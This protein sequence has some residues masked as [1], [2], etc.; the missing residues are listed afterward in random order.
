MIM[1]DTTP[2][3][4]NRRQKTQYV[5]ISAIIVIALAVLAGIIVLTERPQATPPQGAAYQE[6]NKDMGVGSIVSKQDVIDTLGTNG[7]DVKDASISAVLNYKGNRGQTATYN[8]T[9]P[10]GAQ[11]GS[12]DIDIM[13]Y[14]N[15]EAFD[16]AMPLTG[17][18]GLGE[19]AGHQIKYLP[20]ITLSGDRRY[21]ILFANNNDIYKITF[22]QPTV[23]PEILEY[24]AQDMMKELVKKA[25]LL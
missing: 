1:S 16:A 15:K 19:V 10:S 8:F 13:R 20:A 23:K 5:A 9:L 22:I 25:K 21:T 11:N 4:A 18:G 17:T 3:P 2:T 14:A 7:K 24:R 6:R 12:I